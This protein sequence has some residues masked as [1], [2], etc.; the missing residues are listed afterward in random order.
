MPIYDVEVAEIW[1]RKW[2]VTAPNEAR[3]AAVVIAGGGEP[4]AGSAACTGVYAAD[5]LTVDENRSLFRGIVRLLGSDV[6]DDERIP[7]IIGVEEV[8][9][10]AERK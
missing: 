2:R 8:D 7:A 1:H 3:A 9:E 5:G 10:Q 4:Q 6:V